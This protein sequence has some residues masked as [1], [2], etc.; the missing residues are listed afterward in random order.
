MVYTLRFFFSKCSLF[1][2]FIVFGSV[3]FTFFIQ[4]VLKLKKNY[5][6]RKR[7]SFINTYLLF[8]TD[9]RVAQYVCIYY[10][11]HNISKL[12]DFNFLQ[13]DISSLK[14][15]AKRILLLQ[16]YFH[17]LSSLS[18]TNRRTSPS[19]IYRCRFLFR[20]VGL[21][22]RTRDRL[23]WVTFPSFHLFHPDKRRDITFN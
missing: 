3:L 13:D 16:P 10:S 12:T 6:G 2:N 22:P 8:I 23:C 17:V 9:L 1:H 21:K 20:S 14:F 7:L 19:G 11:C 18:Y 5:S 4:G 15:I